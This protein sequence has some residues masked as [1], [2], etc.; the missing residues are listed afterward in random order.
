MIRT[1]GIHKHQWFLAGT[2]WTPHAD[3]AFPIQTVVLK[4]W[5]RSHEARCRQGRWGKQHGKGRGLQYYLHFTCL[6]FFSLFLRGGVSHPVF[7][8]CRLSSMRTGSSLGA[9]LSAPRTVQICWGVWAG[10]APS[11]WRVAASWFTKKPTTL[12]TSTTWAKESILTSTTGRV[13]ATLSALVATST[14]WA[15]FWG[16]SQHNMLHRHQ[17]PA[18][19]MMHS[20]L[21]YVSQWE[22]SFLI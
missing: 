17:L 12:G 15:A 14:R 1:T 18:K 4:G 3:S 6:K 16:Q 22:T 5:H 11:G 19:M 9:I 7:S 13:S 21:I 8:T 10:A 2:I 20:Q